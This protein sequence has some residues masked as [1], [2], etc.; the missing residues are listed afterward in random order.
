MSFTAL[1]VGLAGPT[2]DTVE[3]RGPGSKISRARVFSIYNRIQRA[4]AAGR[5]V[6]DA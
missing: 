4:I 1:T 6:F 3:R 2:L 5:P